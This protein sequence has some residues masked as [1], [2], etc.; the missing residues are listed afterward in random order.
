MDCAG[1]DDKSPVGAWLSLYGPRAASR[2]VCDAR[3]RIL[4]FVALYKWWAFTFYLL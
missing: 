4:R 1:G 2:S 3:R